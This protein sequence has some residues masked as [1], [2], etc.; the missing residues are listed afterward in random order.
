MYLLFCICKEFEVAAN[1][2]EFVSHLGVKNI[3]T[4]RVILWS[5]EVFLCC[6]LWETEILVVN[7]SNNQPFARAA[8]AWLR[9]GLH[10]GAEWQEGNFWV[11][12]G[13]NSDLHEDQPRSELP[14]WAKHHSC[15]GFE[16]GKEKNNKE[17]ILQGG[18]IFFFNSF[19]YFF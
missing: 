17:Q 13:E 8:A 5:L 3:Q 10:L 15:L 19:L 2:N 14:P 4:P 11:C 7:D 16:T 6:Y 18:I 12:D 1:E 9:L